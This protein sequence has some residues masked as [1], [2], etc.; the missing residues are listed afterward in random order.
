MGGADGRR[1]R[2]ERMHDS[3]TRCLARGD[4]ASAGRVTAPHLARPATARRDRAAAPQRAVRPAWN[5]AI[6]STR[7]AG[8]KR[9]GSVAGSPVSSLGTGDRGARRVSSRSK[10]FSATRDHRRRTERRRGRSC[11]PHAA[12][13]AAGC[14]TQSLPVDR[15]ARRLVAE[16][17]RVRQRAVEQPVGH[18]RVARVDDRALPLHQHDVAVRRA[19][20]H[21]PLGR[22]ADEVGDR[23]R[24]R[25][26]PS[27]R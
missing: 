18:A 21:Q 9:T 10:V 27:P 5:P 16:H 6:A 3:R 26:C 25:R 2:V 17:H 14:G 19:L 22:A 15:R 4:R 13:R 24:R 11:M 8:S 7:G 23:P 20:Q 1:V 12:P